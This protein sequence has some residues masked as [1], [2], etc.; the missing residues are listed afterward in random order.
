MEKTEYEF[1]VDDYKKFVK[2]VNELHGTFVY[3]GNNFARRDLR[4]NVYFDGISSRIILNVP[5][6]FIKAVEQIGKGYKLS[7]TD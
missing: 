4:F 6:Y 2:I 3:A 5:G 1:V 7:C